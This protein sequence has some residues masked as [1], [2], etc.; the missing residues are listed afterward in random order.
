M[1][2]VWIVAAWVLLA[3]FAACG[4]A[5]LRGHTMERLAALQLA[6]TIAVLLVLVVAEIAGRSMY[7]G[8]GVTLAIGSAI[9]TLAFVRF[10]E[11][12]L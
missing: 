3:A 12:W 7:L 2:T 8:V 9:G 4:V 1:S 11:R 10:L 6:G 5:C